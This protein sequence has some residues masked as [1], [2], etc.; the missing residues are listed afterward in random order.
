MFWK[1]K[2]DHS[3]TIEKIAVSLVDAG[4]QTGVL[5]FLSLSEAAEYAS[6]KSPLVS[7]GFV[8]CHVV[9]GEGFY[10]LEFKPHPDTGVYMSA[11]YYGKADEL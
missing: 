5:P 6:D 1:Q 11:F 2:R 4:Q 7:P 10:N 8:Q 3:A 9:I